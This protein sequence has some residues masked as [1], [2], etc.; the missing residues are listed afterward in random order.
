MARPVAPD[1]LT[2]IAGAMSERLRHRGPDDS[3]IFVAPSASVALAFRRLAIIDVS[4]AGHQPMTSASGRYTIIFNGEVYNFARLRDHLIREGA[5]PQWRGHS[6][7]EVILAALEAW[8]VEAAVCRFNGMFAIAVWDERERTL[9]L[10]RDRMG[11]KPLYYAKCGD[12]FVFGSELKALVAYEGLTRNVSRDAL[13]LYMRYA[14]VPTPYT[15]YEGVFKQ[16][17]GTI[18]TVSAD[19]ARIEELPFWSVHDAATRGVADRFTGSDEE[20]VAE[21]ERLALDAVG[22]RMIADVPLGVFLSGGVDSSTVTA[23]M[24]AQ[25]SMP[26]KTFSIG[27]SEDEYDE[28]RYAREIARLLGTDHTEMIVTAADAIGVIP[29]LPAMYDEP[30]ADSSQIPTHLVSRLAR[31]H[32]TVSLSGDG[33]DELFG[34]Y[35]RYFLGRQLWERA[36]R[37]PVPARAVASRAMRA[38]PVSIWNR[39][40]SP[41]RR[42][43]PKKLRRERAGERIHKLARAMEARDPDYLYYEVVSQWFD[44]VIDAHELPIAI[45][46]RDTWPALDDFVERMMF[47]DQVSYLPD[48]ILAKVDRASMAVSL[49]S[50]EPLLDHRLV[51]FAWRLPLSMK[52]RHGKGKWILRRLLSRYVPES[53]FERPKMGF[54]VPIEHWLR[55]P[56]RDW[57]ES[58]LDESRLK[59][60]GMFRVDAIRSKWCEHLSGSGEWQ[61]YLW[62]VL[63]F[64][65]WSEASQPSSVSGGVAACIA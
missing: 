49:E 4:P 11:V 34:G 52:L 12:V 30:F 53:L 14:Y 46:R 28:A 40:F 24:Q 60:E 41:R 33:G 51:E 16:T 43:V 17:P 54:G 9:R 56:L 36:Q 21:L 5:A 22:L 10:I 63:M 19:L 38:V 8:G 64:Q 26:V 37:L 7:T 55:G 6:D 1:E 32:V 15:I 39:F 48:D 27:F 25:S 29:Q 2:A 31:R 23:L 61:H 35:H 45:T 20:A 62:T 3:G 57:A 59:R 18:L 50:R 47:A 13:A 42:Y 44:I 65:A 58:L